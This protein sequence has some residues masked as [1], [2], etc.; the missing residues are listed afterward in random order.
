MES[1]LISTSEL[2]KAS[3]IKLSLP[4][5]V[6]MPRD[7][8]PELPEDLASPEFYVTSPP[9]WEK[10]Q[11]WQRWAEKQ[12]DSGLLWQ[13][14]MLK[15]RAATDIAQFHV[16]PEFSDEQTSYFREQRWHIAQ[17]I[18]A[19]GFGEL[20]DNYWPNNTELRL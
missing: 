11:K 10:V 9:L 8:E 17:N 20:L 3:E 14:L 18:R 5:A 6:H 13:E 12:P 19:K 4:F 16:T 7:G 15:E 2:D 1:D